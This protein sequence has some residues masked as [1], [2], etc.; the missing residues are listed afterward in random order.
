MP[1][2]FSIVILIL[3]LF[4]WYYYT[5]FPRKVT[6]CISYDPSQFCTH[7]Q[8]NT[9]LSLQDMSELQALMSTND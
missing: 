9:D 6:I 2:I 1:I 3:Q 7:I 4:N 8:T 5:H